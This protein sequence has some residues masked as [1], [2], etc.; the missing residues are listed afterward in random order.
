MSASDSFVNKINNY[1]AIDDSNISTDFYKGNINEC[2][3]SSETNP[4]S[5][6]EAEE[7]PY[8]NEQQK[9]KIII[10]KEKDYVQF[11]LK[12]KGHDLGF[13]KGKKKRKLVQ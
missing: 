10:K 7:D 3:G 9:D 11:F 13:C 1:S 12:A 5:L 2:Y 4:D 6:S 8:K